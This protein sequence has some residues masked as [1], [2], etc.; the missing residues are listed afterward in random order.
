[1]FETSVVPVRA[2]S[3]RQ[4][5]FLTLSLAAHSCAIAAVVIASVAS[6]HLPV[7]PP[8][9]MSIP[10][11]A[12]PM[13]LPPALGRPEGKTP[14]APQQK[15]PAVP[16]PV[17]ATITAPQTIPEQIPSTASL[18]STSTT[19]GDPGSTTTGNDPIGLPAG[20]PHS[21]STDTSGSATEI[22][23]GPVRVSA[24]VKAPI[25][26]QRVMPE[27]P[28][29]AMLGR[30]NGS[31]I[32]ECVIDRSGHVRDARVIRSSF[33]AFDQPALDAVEKWLFA[34]GTMHGQPVDVIFDLTVTFTL[35]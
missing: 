9:Q 1:M 33:A 20:D 12:R 24:D 16:A 31:V 27:Y 19:V 3:P 21:T 5:S 11:L 13:I 10:I 25:V 35:H 29:V 18:A 8:R 17:R 6:V 34:P 23:T 30:M 4:Y 2:A 7:D 15:R 22:P 28:R 32:V 26:L 14:P